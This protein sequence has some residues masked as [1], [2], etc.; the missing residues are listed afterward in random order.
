MI[1][2]FAF[3]SI[4]AWSRFRR[5]KKELNFDRNE[6]IRY[7]LSNFTQKMSKIVK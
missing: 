4:Q 3:S 7:E 2:K 5:E 6:L 1:A